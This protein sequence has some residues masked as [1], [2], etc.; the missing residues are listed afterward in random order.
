MLFR[1]IGLRCGV[2]CSNDAMLMIGTMITVPASAFASMRGMSRCSA[3]I[4]LY[5]VP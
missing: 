4:E 1:S 5:S 2:I 3:T